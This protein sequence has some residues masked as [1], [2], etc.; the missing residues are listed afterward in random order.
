[1]FIHGVSYLKSVFQYIKIAIIPIMVVVANQSK[2]MIHALNVGVDVN[3]AIKDS[4][5]RRKLI[6]VVNSCDECE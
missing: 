4:Y 3:V 5:P 2:A 1:V 6:D